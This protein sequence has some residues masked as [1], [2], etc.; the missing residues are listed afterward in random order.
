MNAKDIIS[1]Q[2]FSYLK[3]IVKISPETWFKNIYLYITE[4]CQ[5]RCKH[6][7]LGKRLKSG[8]VMSKKEVF[9]NLSIWKK[10]GGKKICFLGGEP[11]LHPQFEEI[12]QYANKL[13][14]ES[15]T[16][17]TN[18]LKISLDKLKNLNPSDFDYIQ[19]S[20]DGGSSATNDKIRGKNSFDITSKTIIELCK[21]NFDVRIICTVNRYNLKDCLKILPFAEHSGVTLVKY[22]IFSG[23]GTGK[24]NIKW[25]LSPKEWR[26]FTDILLEQKEKYKTKIQFQPAYGEE[27]VK[28]LY[29]KQGY[30]GCVGRN[31][32]RVSIFPNGSVYICSYL[33]DTDLNFANLKN[34]KLHIK[35]T[36]SEL[37]LFFSTPK[38]CKDCKFN[39][40]CFGSCPAE[41]IVQGHLSCNKHG[42]YPI[43]RLWKATI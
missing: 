30:R 4:S 24:E 8:D 29:F 2:D 32:D 26:N 14:Y 16:L 43:C 38:K 35:K 42:V 12:V 22:H 28:Q 15:V 33:F 17:D 36:H 13:K 11:T 31:L 40:V 27:K 5:L 19:I 34:N 20:L 6:C 41:K 23:I 1:S 10:L 7:Y 18:G 3:K 39:N 25:V 37:D 9:N 21:S